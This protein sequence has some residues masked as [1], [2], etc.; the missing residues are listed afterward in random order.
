LTC[1]VEVVFKNGKTP[2]DGNRVH[3]WVEFTS[4]Y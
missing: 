2:S 1:R 4:K 3:P